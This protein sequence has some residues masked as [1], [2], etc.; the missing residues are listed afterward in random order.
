M[1]LPRDRR[2]RESLTFYTEAVW[3]AADLVALLSAAED[4]Y[5]VFLAKLFW[6]ETMRQR[7]NALHRMPPRFWRELEAW[8]FPL[9]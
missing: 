5:R 8:G 6:M 4:L 3:R 2:S 9:V 1:P 7:Q